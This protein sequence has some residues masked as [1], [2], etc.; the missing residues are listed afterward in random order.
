M[1]E[2]KMKKKRKIHSEEPQLITLTFVL[3]RQL[4]IEGLR[5]VLHYGVSLNASDF[6]FRSV[7]YEFE[8]LCVFEK[9]KK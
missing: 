6:C 2:S 8:L 5:V 4:R 1:V 7:F 3:F 9:Q